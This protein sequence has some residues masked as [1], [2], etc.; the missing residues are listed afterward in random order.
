M[1]SKLT[2]PRKRRDAKA[3]RAGLGTD[4]AEPVTS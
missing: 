1:N 2:T 4:I 3:H